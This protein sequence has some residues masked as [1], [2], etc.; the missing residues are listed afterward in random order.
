MTK[1]PLLVTEEVKILRHAQNA[2]AQAAIHAV[3][4]AVA[5]TGRMTSEDGVRWRGVYRFEEDK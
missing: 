4:E 5:F 1:R 2:A 3:M